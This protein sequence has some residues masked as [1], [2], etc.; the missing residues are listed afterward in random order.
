VS[1]ASV[2]RL[3][4]KGIP[5]NALMRAERP[6]LV[7]ARDRGVTVSAGQDGRVGTTSCLRVGERRPSRQPDWILISEA[8]ISRSLRRQLKPF[9]IGGDGD[10][11]LIEEAGEP[12]EPECGGPRLAE[13][14]WCAPGVGVCVAGDFEAHDRHA[15]GD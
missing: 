9:F 10:V 14:D 5:T 3:P 4:R 8:G 1:R 11:E 13:P 2:T 6:K 7:A 15:R 12:E